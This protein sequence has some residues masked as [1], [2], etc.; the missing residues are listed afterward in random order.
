MIHNEKITMVVGCTKPDLCDDTKK[1][2]K[3]GSLF[4]EAPR[5]GQIER[6]VED[7][8]EKELDKS[9]LVKFEMTQLMPT[10]LEFVPD[11][12]VPVPEIEDLDGQTQLRWT[13]EEDNATG[14]HTVTYQV[15]PLEEG[16]WEVGGDLSFLDVAD[17]GRTLPMPA[18]PI[19]VDGICEP[20]ETPPTPTFT[21]EPTATDTPEPPATDTPEPATATPRP[22]PIYIP[23]TLKEHC[24]AD[25]RL[26]DIALVIDMSS[27]MDRMT[28]DG[29]PKKQAVV[30]AAQA[31][32]AS[33][34]F[35]PNASDQNDQVAIVGFN[36]TAWIQQALTRDAEAVDAALL[37]LEEQMAHGTRLDLAFQKGAEALSE[38][39][40]KPSNT[41]VIIL[42]TDGVP[43]GVPVDPD[44]GTAEDTVLKSA[45]AAKDT[46]ITIYTIG[47]GST[48]ESADPSD[49]VNAELLQQC[50]SDPSKA[51]IDPRA[52]RLMEIYREIAN[53]FTCPVGR[54]DWSQPWP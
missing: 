25:E 44:S 33:L 16:V 9:E 42:L 13:W 20:E 40:R 54:H 29:V 28:E 1:M 37:A 21:P 52:D 6:I 23:V 31:F 27:S 10:G 8:L 46:G 36:G 11:S 34:D 35:T 51:Y 18:Q 49:R 7:E 39:L 32:V 3:S 43:N 30:E 48:D 24:S 17:L 53:V 15:M 2:P 41:P 19:T 5:Q 45:Q 4:V 12:A 22:E 26:G 47:F 50:A 38:D 14:A